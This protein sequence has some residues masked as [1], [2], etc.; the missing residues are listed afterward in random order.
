MSTTNDSILNKIRGTS[1]DRELVVKNLMNDQTLRQK[2]VRLVKSKSGS[3]QDVEIIFDDMIVTFIKK[4]MTN[5]SL[6]IEDHIHSYLIGIAKYLWKNYWRR[7]QRH[8]YENID[9]AYN[10]T[11]SE[12]FIEEILINKESKTIINK[13]LN[14]IHH[15]C[16]SL[17]L[18]WAKDYSMVEIVELLSFTS[19]GAVRK[20]KSDCLKSLRKFLDNNPETTRQLKNYLLK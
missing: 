13:V 4:V 7:E 1:E 16:K 17:L 18:Y 9:N 5:R 15:K 8:T 10:S 11:S 14:Q 2:V 19:E 3:I 20:K 6:K 12:I